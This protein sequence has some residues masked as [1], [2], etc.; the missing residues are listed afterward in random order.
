MRG[1][2]RF[3][4][5]PSDKWRNFQL[6]NNLR[7]VRGT[8]SSLARTIQHFAQYFNRNLEERSPSKFTYKVNH[9]KY[10]FPFWLIVKINR[11]LLQLEISASGIESKLANV[12]SVIFP[13]IWKVTYKIGIYSEIF[14]KTSR[15]LADQEKI[16]PLCVK[17][18]LHFG[19][20]LISR[21]NIFF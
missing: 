21:K 3:H 16:L 10:L 13:E 12:H 4:Y 9:K 5:L 7:A 11:Y 19:Y 17:A 14:F 1:S 8:T 2:R 15:S 6:R 18:F 20:I